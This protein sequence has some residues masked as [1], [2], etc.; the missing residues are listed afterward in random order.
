MLRRMPGDHTVINERVDGSFPAHHPGPDGREEPGAVAR[1]RS[2]T[3]NC[4][5]GIAFDGDADRIGVID[6][7]GRVIWGDQLLLAIL[8][9]DV[10]STHAPGDAGHRRCEGQPGPVR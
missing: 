8:A 1:Q 9:R 5:L 10:L 4:D 6:G 7:K 3:E 2:L